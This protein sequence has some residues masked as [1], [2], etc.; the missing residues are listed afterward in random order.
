MIV[1]NLA[2]EYADQGQGPVILML[3]GWGGS[4]HGFDLLVNDL[5]QNHRVIRLDLPGFGGTDAPTETWNL[6]NYI[7]F[8]K[9]FVNKLFPVDPSSPGSSGWNS[10]EA[11][12]GHSF[13]C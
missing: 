10:I 3:H 2:T 13:C 11:I 7:S 8:T 12:I 6:D 4:L 5:V 9:N 1:D